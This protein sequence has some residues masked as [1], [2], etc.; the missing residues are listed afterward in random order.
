MSLYQRKEKRNSQHDKRTQDKCPKERE[1]ETCDNSQIERLK[2]TAKKDDQGYY[3]P[4]KTLEDYSLIY[5]GQLTKMHIMGKLIM[6]Q[7]G[8]TQ[9]ESAA[10]LRKGDTHNTRLSLR[11]RIIESNGI[12]NKR[13]S[14]AVMVKW[15]RV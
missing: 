4:G 14:K 6:V 11:N 2:T 13:R 7:K 10:I 5:E 3:D 15:K 8:R 12:W 9:S 1:R